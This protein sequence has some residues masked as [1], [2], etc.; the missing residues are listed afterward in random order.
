MPGFPDAQ[1]VSERKNEI[2]PQFGRS[3]NALDDGGDHGVA[4]E[5]ESVIV[6]TGVSQQV[7]DGRSVAPVY[8]P[9]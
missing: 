9:S 5:L 3:F 4:G 7:D 6:G 2:V 1:P 8:G